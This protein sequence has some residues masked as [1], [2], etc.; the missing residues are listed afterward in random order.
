MTVFHAGT[1]WENDQWVVRG[2]RAAYVVASAATREE[3]KDKSYA[4]IADVG[5]SGWRYRTD[6]AADGV[7]A[8]ASRP[9]MGSGGL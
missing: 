9:N 3:A 4:A 1:R 2:G 7:S 8:G 6:I 5:G